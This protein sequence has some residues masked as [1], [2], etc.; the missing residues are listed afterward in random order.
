MLFRIFRSA[1]VPQI[2]PFLF[3]SSFPFVSDS[4][5]FWDGGFSEDEGNFFVYS[6][7]SGCL[8]G[9]Q[10]QN[11]GIL[12]EFACITLFWRLPET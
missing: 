10:G 3:S 1:S 7:F 6:V 4:R 8:A 11:Y 9:F 5:N 12:C 2:F